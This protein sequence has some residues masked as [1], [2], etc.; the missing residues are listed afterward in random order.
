MLTGMRRKFNVERV[1]YLLGEAEA[2]PLADRSVD[3]AF[4][5]MCLHH[6]E[7]P[8]QAIREMAR[9]LRPEGVLVITDLDEHS[10][11]FLREEH[12]DCWLSFRREDT[13]AGSL[14][15][16]FGKSRWSAQENAAVPHP[17]AGRSSQTSASSWLP[18]RNHSLLTVRSL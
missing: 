16:G 12:H 15:L 1:A 6:V 9:I 18:G 10:F 4:T 7:H 8:P 2:L 11:E 13:S 5:N 3:Y 17:A 14:R